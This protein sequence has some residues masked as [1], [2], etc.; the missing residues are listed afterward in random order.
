MDDNFYNDN[1]FLTGK[2]A[3]KLYAK[4][5]DL[6]IYDYHSHVPPKEIYE[7]KV[8]E[9]IGQ[10]WLAA[11]HYKWRL[12]RAAGVSEEYITG[13]KNYK[14][15]FLKFASA[16]ETCVGNPVYHWVHFELKKYFDI[17]IPLCK[18]NAEKIWEQANKIIAQKK[19]SPK[20]IINMSNVAYIGT[21]DDIADDLAYHKKIKAD[22]KFKTTVAPS[23]RTDNLLLIQKDT[24][25]EYITKLSAAAGIEIDSLA[26]LKKAVEK[27]LDYF[28]K[29]G[30][31]F[32]DVGISI[33][34]D[35]IAVES[36]AEQIFKKALAGKKPTDEE[37]N[38]FVGFM[39]I[40]LA[41]LYKSR[42]MVMQLH[43]GVMR[44]V[45]SELFKIGP[46][47]GCDV[48]GSSINA[49]AFAKLLNAM[50]ERDGLPRTIV[51]HLN[52]TSYY[53]LSTVAGAFKNVTMG[54]AWWF[55]D[56]AKGMKEHLQMLCE[57][58]NLGTFY[59]ML[60]DSRSFLSYPRHDYFRRVLASFIA[61]KID[62]GEYP[63]N[64][65]A[66]ELLEKICCKNVKNIIEV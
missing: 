58:S 51:Y 60:S 44:N 45:N 16:I 12:M 33:F 20:V 23:F 62:A 50:N 1:I 14:E 66:A 27:R 8:F 65:I 4:I 18:K 61:K 32:T 28:A 26:A 2:T 34:P 52:P 40:Y 59:G 53:P 56:H 57:T 35:E 13:T 21:T 5:K 43:I 64:Q 37:F 11:D 46:D 41:G 55:N 54:A 7:D 36:Q 49:V 39:Y 25:K 24:Y 19:L 17:H 10:V 42:G 31:V 9:N 6:P 30:C 22:K 48:V 38:K 63:D 15:K 29:N 3:K 47:L